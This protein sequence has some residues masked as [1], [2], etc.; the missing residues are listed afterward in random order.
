MECCWR[1]GGVVGDEHVSA[2]RQG[3]DGQRAKG[4][5]GGVERREG[6]RAGGFGL[7]AVVLAIRGESAAGRGGVVCKIRRVEYMPTSR[8]RGGEG[9]TRTTG[10]YANRKHEDMVVQIHAVASRAISA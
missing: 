10:V 6:G 1:G 8:G 7:E 3:R 9:G 2:L 4:G 5:G